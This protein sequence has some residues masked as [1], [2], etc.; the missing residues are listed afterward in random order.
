MVTEL[1]ANFMNEQELKESAKRFKEWDKLTQDLF[2]SEY[3]DISNDTNVY[4]LIDP[5][6][7]ENPRGFANIERLAS[8]LSI[9]YVVKRVSMAIGK[10]PYELKGI[11]M[12][13]SED[14]VAAYA[15]EAGYDF[16][17]MR[18]DEFLRIYD[19]HFDNLFVFGDEKMFVS[20]ANEETT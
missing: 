13:A 5:H 8:I 4:V 6:G 3:E 18:K 10:S 1:D 9:Q 16:V 11:F 12:K 7:I 19:E 17:I 14:E 20:N 2:Q 15:K